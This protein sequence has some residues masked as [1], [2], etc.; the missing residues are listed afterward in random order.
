MDKMKLTGKNEPPPKGL[1]WQVIY[2]RAIKIDP[3]YKK[4][5]AKK[6]LRKVFNQEVWTNDLYMAT[7]NRRM[8]KEVSAEIAE[9]SIT[10]KDREPIHDWRHF[11]QIKNDIVGEDSE[12][13]EIYP[14]EKRLMDTANTYWL[15][16]FP[17]D[18]IVPFGFNVDLKYPPNVMGTEEAMEAGAVQRELENKDSKEVL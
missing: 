10:R 8:N 3:T 6:F 7:V 11:Q 9:I 5:R 15:Y 14:N 16:A 18:Y 13:I 12:A 4:A 2:K 17:K 1:T